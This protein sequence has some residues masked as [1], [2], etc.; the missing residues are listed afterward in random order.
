MPERRLT[1]VPHDPDRVP[2]IEKIL[3]DEARR[4]VA[5]QRPG[6][7]DR[8]EHVAAQDDELFTE[9][10]YEGNGAGHDSGEL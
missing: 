10:A 7:S 6:K 5:C 9:S 4:E 2:D 1:R 8:G 3:A